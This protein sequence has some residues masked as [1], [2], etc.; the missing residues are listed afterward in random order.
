MSY[1]IQKNQKWLPEEILKLWSLC[2]G[3]VTPPLGTSDWGKIVWC[4][5]R[6][7]SWIKTLERQSRKYQLSGTH[8]YWQSLPN[9][10]SHQMVIRIAVSYWAILKDLHHKL[11]CRLLSIS[12][13]SMWFIFI[14]EVQVHL[15]MFQCCNIVLLATR[16]F[17]C[18][19]V[20]YSDTI[21]TT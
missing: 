20:Y 4:R 7:A 16:F 12:V 10:C 5:G 13:W 2:N 9:F 19:I 3:C 18:G 8:Y 21:I 6:V 15:C 14:R 1:I 17:C 11:E